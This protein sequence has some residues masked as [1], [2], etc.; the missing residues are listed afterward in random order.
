[1]AIPSS[2]MSRGAIKAIFS[3]KILNSGERNP[4]ELVSFN[5]ELPGV[6][7]IR[8]VLVSRLGLPSP[9]TLNWGALCL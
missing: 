3:L 7:K 8:L 2:V 4:Y 6:R 5:S 9:K 1:M